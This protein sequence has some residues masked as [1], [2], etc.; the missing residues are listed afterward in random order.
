MVLRDMKNKFK[1]SIILGIFLIGFLNCGGSDNSTEDGGGMG[2]YQ[3]DKSQKN[4]VQIAIGSPDHTTLVTAVKAAD[5]VDS[6][7]NPGPFTVFAPVNAAF[8][9][10]PDGVVSDL[11]KP[12]NKGKLEDILYHHVFIGVL[13]EE[14]LK[15]KAGEEVNMFA[16]GPVKIEVKDGKLVVDGANVVASIPASNGII[17]VVDKVFL[18]KSE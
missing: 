10:L 6:L 12:A 18:P 16:G 7:A 14:Y 1:I 2:S 3:D 11:L 15:G 8:D 4:V 13:N 5:L 17:H 9:A